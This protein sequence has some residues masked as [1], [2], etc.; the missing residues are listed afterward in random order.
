MLVD[1]RASA[2]I[3]APQLGLAGSDENLDAKAGLLAARANIAPVVVA[4]HRLGP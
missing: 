2:A 1:D 4:V 3:I